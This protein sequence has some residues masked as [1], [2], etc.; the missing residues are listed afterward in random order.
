MKHTLKSLFCIC[1]LMMGGQ[2]YAQTTAES[3]QKK[4]GNFAQAFNGVIEKGYQIGYTNTPYYPQEYQSGSFEFRG[5]KYTNV[6]LRTDS[7][8]KNLL[9]LSPDGKF[10]LVMNPEEV[11]HIVIGGVPF[12][13]FKAD[14]A[15]PGSGYYTILY[16]GKDFGIYKQSYVSNIS[17]EYKGSTVVQKFSL[18]ER[19]FLRKD[20]NWNVLTNKNGFIK[21]FKAHKDALNDYCKQHGL[22]FGKKNET[23][24]QKLATYCE[25]L[26]K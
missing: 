22:T 4:A 14:E 16:E 12:Q 13:Y 20:G 24:W 26:T 6:K 25:T 8:A 2:L 10:N 9:A 18:K 15:A 3:Y 21:H 5:L 7:Y 1:L 11:R 17:K 23:D 19:I